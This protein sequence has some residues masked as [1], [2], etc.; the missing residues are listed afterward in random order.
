MRNCLDPLSFT[1]RKPDVLGKVM[2]D[3][4]AESLL[5]DH[6]DGGVDAWVRD[7]AE[8][9][10]DWF[11]EQDS[12]LRFTY[13]SPMHEVVTGISP[14]NL[15]GKSRRQLFEERGGEM[16]ENW[17][18]HFRTIERHESYRNFVYVM[19]RP[20]GDRRVIRNSGKAI[21]DDKGVFTG[22][23][24]VGTDITEQVN[25]EEA[26]LKAKDAAE[27]ADRA[28]S[29]FL[30]SVSHELRTPVTSIRG[31]LGLLRGGT[32]G[33]FPEQAIEMIEVAHDNAV[34]LANLIDDILDM[35]RISSGDI[36]Y[37]M[38]PVNL[39]QLLE[40]AVSANQRFANQFKV[41]LEFTP[42]RAHSAV[43]LGNKRRLRQVMNN[44]LTNAAKFSYEHGRVAVSLGEMQGLARITVADEGRGIPETFR[45]QAFAPFT[46]ADPSASRSRGGTGL[47]LGI[48]QAIVKSHGGKLHFES[49]EGCGTCF[50]VDLPLIAEN[51][52]NLHAVR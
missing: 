12:N 36:E 21:F 17:R 42:D 40:R 3:A 5:I 39:R 23:R 49:Q 32:F 35:E 31:S 33:P 18:E 37:E 52:A 28:K 27:S 13:L 48:S 1:P 47:G 38:A 19:T 16:D 10:S 6:T 43:V 34:R 15:L 41:H 2:K 50:F 45:S 26:L 11:W 7:F 51:G 25:R 30:A 22:Y 24:G 20:D 14:E 29:D 8:S 9:V 46:Q 44:L 4:A